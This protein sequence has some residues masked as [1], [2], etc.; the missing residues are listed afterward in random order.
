MDN[1]GNN[2]KVAIVTLYGDFNFG[3]K[4][5][6][7]AVQEILKS[8]NYRCSTIRCQNTSKAIGWKGTLVA[9][10][11][12]PK[13]IAKFERL[14]LKNKNLFRPFS[15]RYLDLGEK[16]NYNKA[17]GFPLTYDYYITGS[18][19]VWGCVTKEQINYFFLRFVPSYKRLCISP[20]FGKDSV[21]DRTEKLYADGLNGFRHLSCREES[22]CRII[23]ELTGRDA[24][25][26]CDPTMAITKE[27]WDK[28]STKPSFELPE[29]YILTY[30]LG[31]APEEAVNHAKAL[32][33]KEGIPI[34]NLYD[35]NYPEYA[36]VQPDEFIYLVKHSEHFFTTSFHGCVFSVIY[37]TPFTVFERNDMSNSHGR[38]ETLLKK[39]GL[40]N[41]NGANVKSEN[42]CD[43]SDVD[44][45]L[46]AER[47][48]MYE[49]IEMIFTDA[50]KGD[51]M[52]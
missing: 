27:Q 7:Y 39:F 5:Q 15:E 36:S 26:L 29:R 11:G 4:L 3:N 33:E 6:N 12:F 2:K 22:G 50:E 51:D 35:W 28:I 19:Q 1:R 30:F 18:D 41:C 24:V 10:L 23:K 37:H 20:S 47:K 46:E 42:S 13:H 48:K 45:I 8:F 16:I 40:E 32:S 43:F 25:L 52:Q 31:T 9:L 34:I 21:P 49:Y 38:I 14:L 44:N 17:N